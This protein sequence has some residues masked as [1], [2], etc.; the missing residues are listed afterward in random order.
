MTPRYD[1]VGIGNAIVD[2]IFAADD[3][4]LLTHKIAKGSMMLV[5]EFRAQVLLEGM[6]SPRETSGGSAANTMAGLASF[7][8]KGLFIGKVKD[9]RLGV[10]FADD[11]RRI[12]CEYRTP[13]AKHGPSTACCAI[14]VTPDGQRSM[15]TYLGACREM[16]PGDIDEAAIG[17]CKFIYIEGY[18]WDA[19]ASK[20]EIGRAHV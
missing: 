13:M 6:A 4:F 14:A 5:D 1:V 20:T 2:I 17:E 11:L 15:S 9:D 19:E 10:S 12:G 8:G 7:Q 3:Q 18:L 16:T